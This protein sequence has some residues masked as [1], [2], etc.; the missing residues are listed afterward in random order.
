MLFHQ[1]IMND[2][3]KLY[4]VVSAN[5]S[6]A[7]FTSS[8]EAKEKLSANMLIVNNAN[9][10]FV[11]GSLWCWNVCNIIE[12]SVYLLSKQVKDQ[13]NACLSYMYFLSSIFRTMVI[14]KLI[15]PISYPGF[16]LFRWASMPFYN[17]LKKMRRCLNRDNQVTR[18]EAELEDSALR[19][20]V[21]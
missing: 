9:S 10:C 14:G 15:E 21:I 1:Q 6:R 19:T 17:E 20:I 7:N 11:L 5:H 18:S 12:V 16:I 13:H 3:D 2:Q 4:D 8:Y